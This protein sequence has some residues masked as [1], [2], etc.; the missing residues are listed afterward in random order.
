MALAGFSDNPVVS[1]IDPPL[2]TVR[3]PAHDIGETA[4]RML[5]ENI[6]NKEETK[7]T[8][9]RILKTELIVRLST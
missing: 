3:Q 5:I 8:G 1:L 6:L 9:T 7:N 4:A 2:T